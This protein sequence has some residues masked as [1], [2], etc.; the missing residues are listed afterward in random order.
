MEPDDDYWEPPVEGS[1]LRVMW[2]ETAGPLWGDEGLLPEEPEWL[3]PVLALS[4]GL[5]TDLLQWLD[6]M[7][8]LHLGSADERLRLSQQGLNE[9]G[10]VLAQRVQAEVG[11]RYR[12]RYHG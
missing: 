6:D 12:V 3:G 7:T 2:D 11:T 4:D 9:L 1:E 8:A 5:V 10:E